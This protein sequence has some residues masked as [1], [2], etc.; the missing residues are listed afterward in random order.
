VLQGEGADRAACLETYLKRTGSARCELLVAGWA[1]SNMSPLDFLWSEAPVFALDDA[2]AALAAQLVDAADKAGFAL[3][4]A[5]KQGTG[6]EDLQSG[7]ANRAREMFFVRTQ[8]PFEALLDAL[9]QGQGDQVPARWLAEMKQVALSLFDAEVLPGLADLSE[10]RRADAIA[11]RRNL[12]GTF[13]GHGAGRKLYQAL[14][15]TPPKASR[16][17]KETT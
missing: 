15:M 12:L 2:G 13:N 9:Q 3:A 7:A 6:Q 4:A 14:G 1:M 8:G 5:V 16:K 10:T 17:T 11:A